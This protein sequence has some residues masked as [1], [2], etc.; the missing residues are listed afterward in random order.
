MS[1]EEKQ[2]AE[3]LLLDRS[4]PVCRATRR[5]VGEDPSGVLHWRKTS[6]SKGRLQTS[7]ARFSLG[8]GQ[9]MGGRA[10]E[11]GWE[12]PADL[13]VQPVGD[14]ELSAPASTLPFSPGKLIHVGWHPY[15]QFG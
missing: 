7:D 2:R 11:P 15:I 3:L 12:T 14:R 4:L 6:W 13:W 1:H 10:P 5:A 8:H 9:G